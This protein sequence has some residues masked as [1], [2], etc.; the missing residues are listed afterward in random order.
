MGVASSSPLANPRAARHARLGKTLLRQAADYLDARLGFLF[1]LPVLIIV[2]YLLIYPVVTSFY[3]SLT[4][5]HL[6]RHGYT[7]VGL[8]NYRQVFADREL[9]EALV[10][11]GV[12]TVGS[13]AFQLLLGL[14]GAL[15][16]N[17]RMTFLWLWRM[18]I[19]V[20]WAFPP[21]VIAFTWRWI[22]NDLYGVLNYFLVALHLVNMPLLFLG[23]R[24]LA[25]PTAIGVN[26]WFGFPFFLL[27]ILAAL[28]S[29]PETEYEAARIEGATACQ[30]FTYVIFPRIRFT[31]G[32]I[33]V[34]RTMWVVNSFD[35]I[36]LLT[37]GGPGTTTQTL[38]VFAYFTGW[39]RY[40]LGRASAICVV[41]L[42]ILVL[43][44]WFYFRLFQLSQVE[45]E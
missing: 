38:P 23:S 17:R 11:T 4:N 33:L 42:G 22:L 16:L 2:A 34:L 5:R 30:T 28:Q 27:A 14:A 32:I 37:G 9:W 10:N 44:S 20:P 19:I 6:L 29:I 13:L 15:L 12:W 39:R 1:I 7:F 36:F 31:L 8:D 45:E 18:L 21:I 24:S 25:M 26:T 40:F 43:S 35:F 41:L 3:I